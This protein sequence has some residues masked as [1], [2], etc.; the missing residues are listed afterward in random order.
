M[1]VSQRTP[2]VSHHWQKKRDEQEKHKVPCRSIYVSSLINQSHHFQCMS[3]LVS[4]FPYS[5][6]VLASANNSQIEGQIQKGSGCF[7]C[8][9]LLYWRVLN[10]WGLAQLEGPLH[11]SWRASMYITFRMGN[12]LILMSNPGRAHCFQALFTEFSFSWGHGVPS[13]NTWH[14]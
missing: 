8:C 1:S 13:W 12:F 4:L 9:Y 14:P 2:A 6:L 3:S 7:Q 5:L 10:I 11:L